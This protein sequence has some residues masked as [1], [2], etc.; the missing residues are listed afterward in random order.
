M[1]PIKDLAFDG[2]FVPKVCRKDYCLKHLSKGRI[3][4]IDAHLAVTSVW[5]QTFGQL[6]LVSCPK[7][8]FL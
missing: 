2:M 7:V 8:L 6:K 3:I 1:W 5:G 4:A